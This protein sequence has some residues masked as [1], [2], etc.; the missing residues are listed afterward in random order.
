MR[1]CDFCAIVEE[2][3]PAATV[4]E[5]G[6]NM[7]FFPLRPAALGHTLVIP[8]AHYADLFEVPDPALCDL[9]Q[10]VAVVGRGIRA[11]LRPDGI[12]VINSSGKAASQTVFH[13]HVHLV[14]RWTGDRF[15]NIWP[16]SEIQSDEMKVEVVE[17]LR[18]QLNS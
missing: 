10:A 14:P 18:T 2:R 16:P 8:K 11:A 3:A 9:M 12:N 13:V 4:W 1:K 17:M 5:D 7:A 6:S 15:G